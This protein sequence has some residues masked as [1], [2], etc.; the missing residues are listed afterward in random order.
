MDMG[1]QLGRGIQDEGQVWVTGLAQRGGHADAD[2]I[3]CFQ[4]GKITG[5]IQPAGCHQAGHL[6]GRHVLDVAFTPAD[7]IHLALVRVNAGNVKAGFGEGHRQGQAYVAQAQYGNLGSLVF[8]PAKQILFHHV[9]PLVIKLELYNAQSAE[10]FLATS[11]TIRK[12]LA[13]A[14]CRPHHRL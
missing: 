5:G 6:F 1:G 11:T 13:V 9:K 10:M 7:R 2:C 8:Y 14:L 4:A 3:G 12:G